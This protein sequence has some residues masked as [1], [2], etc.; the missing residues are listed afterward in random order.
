MKLTH[1]SALATALVLSFGQASG[2][3]VNVNSATLM[4]PDAKTGEV[5]TDELRRVLADGT[6]IVIDARARAEFEAGHIPGAHLVDASAGEQV[7]AV[8]RL[9]N[10]NKAAALVVYCN[11]PFCQASRRLADL[12]S[13]SGFKNVKRYQLG[14][15]V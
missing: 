4:E 10:G 8:E 15:P 2:Q 1:L 9:V 14:M 6:A 3:T 7:A 12:L 5:S 11:G 13:A